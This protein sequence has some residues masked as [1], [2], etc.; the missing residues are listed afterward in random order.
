MRGEEPLGRTPRAARGGGDDA[1]SSTFGD[2]RR[3]RAATPRGDASAPRTTRDHLP[4]F[5][6]VG[7]AAK[8]RS[9]RLV[10]FALALL[11]LV[12]PVPVGG[13]LGASQ[14]PSDDDS[15]R[16]ASFPLTAVS[17]FA[18]ASTLDE[19]FF[20][21]T[22]DPDAALAHDP[23]L[24]DTSAFARGVYKGYGVEVTEDAPVLRVAALPHLANSTVKMRSYAYNRTVYTWVNSTFN[25]T[26]NITTN[27]TITEV[28]EEYMYDGATRGWVTA[29]NET[30][31]DWLSATVGLVPLETFNVTTVEV[32]VISGVDRRWNAT[33][34]LAVTRSNVTYGCPGATSPLGCVSRESTVASPPS[35]VRQQRTTTLLVEGYDE[36]GNKRHVGG[37]SAGIVATIANK[38]YVVDH[39]ADTTTVVYVDRQTATVEDLGTGNYL[40]AFAPGKAG[41]YVMDV[42][43][44]GAAHPTTHAF[45]V[46]P[47]RALASDFTVSPDA[48][49]VAPGASVGSFLAGRILDFT[50]RSADELPDDFEAS[51][52]ITA[53]VQYFG[54]NGISR[55]TWLATRGYTNIHGLYIPPGPEPLEVTRNPARRERYFWFSETLGGEYVINVKL[56]DDHVGAS[57]YTITVEGGDPVNHLA[58]GRVGLTT[59]V[60]KSGTSPP[61][62]ASDQLGEHVASA[63]TAGDE[64]FIDVNLRDED[65]NVATIDVANRELLVK[66]TD[67][68][69]TRRAGDG[70]VV[71][72]SV[73]RLFESAVAGFG[74]RAA[75]TLPRPGT[76]AVTVQLG[77]V[78]LCLTSIDPDATTCVPNV[79]VNVGDADPAGSLVLGAGAASSVR[80]GDV[81]S[82]HVIP[83]DARGNRIE[84]NSSAYAVTITCVTSRNP[85][86][87]DGASIVSDA[88]MSYDAASDDGS[89]AYEY[90]LPLAGDYAVTVK[91]TSP[92]TAGATVDALTVTVVPGDVAAVRFDASTNPDRVAGADGA[93]DF[94]LVD[95]EG[96]VASADFASDVRVIFE[97]SATGA[98]SFVSDTSEHAPVRVTHDATTGA[99]AVEYNLPVAD[100]YAVRVFFRDAELFDATSKTVT[101]SAGP[102][103]AATTV[104]AGVGLQRAVVGE[105]ASFVVYVADRYGNV[106]TSPETGLVLSATASVTVDGDDPTCEPGKVTALDA[107]AV[108]LAWDAV[109]GRYE[110]AY[111]PHTAGLLSVRLSMSGG[112]GGMGAVAGSPFAARVK[113]GATRAA[114]CDA[115]GAGLRGAIVGVGGVVY[116]TARDAHG[117]ARLAGGDAVHARVV[118]TAGV[119]SSPPTSVTDNGDGTYVVEYVPAAASTTYELR[120]LIGGEHVAGSPYA[121]RA[122]SAAGAVSPA[123]T[124]AFG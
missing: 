49:K 79:V 45:R 40:L 21:S 26:T 97:K 111:T 102:A 50:I 29:S 39:R 27:E 77:G 84:E 28:L 75:A 22:H 78:S 124:R 54:A 16:L 52:E 55:D 116:I 91:Q 96:N 65:G 15:T 66:Y 24:A 20:V 101:V 105:E 5:G 69:P 43:F 9:G 18:P 88:A 48:D 98:R 4:G 82:L 76:Y 68:S 19:V 113:P 81:V 17:H 121:V 92:G 3:G 61:A 103:E 74:Y 63:F 1:I 47:R 72:A 62:N 30:G 95:A 106:L 109:A 31:G 117:N 122:V 11:A 64:L 41:D 70:G 123:N 38:K 35:T 71:A 94:D 53:D 110:G 114:E 99:H 89:H 23:S 85:N 7:Y 33:Y 13:Q 37:E 12:L 80:A 107:S 90:R 118:D 58:V 100:A 2:R 8:R 83:L 59:A 67:T 36:H 51:A 87:A 10:S 14:V 42:K 25:A 104:A 86:I 73:T 60:Y 115:D 44:W 34:H 108:A 93:L 56:G 57:P 32:L 120:M 46:L 112:S 6:R 119:A